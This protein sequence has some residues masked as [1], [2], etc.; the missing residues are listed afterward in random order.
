M[1]PQDVTHTA[2]LSRLTVT[3]SFAFDL[4]LYSLHRRTSY[5]VYHL[6]GDYETDYVEF[7]FKDCVG[8]HSGDRVWISTTLD[9]PYSNMLV[10]YD[11]DHDDYLDVDNWTINLPV[12][13]N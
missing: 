3:N 12:T 9:V 7:A 11:P 1:V 4:M 8:N 2:H 13:C 10:L 6:M 5:G